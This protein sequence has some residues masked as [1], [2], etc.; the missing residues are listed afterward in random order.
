MGFLSAM[1]PITVNAIV[2]TVNV[3]ENFSQV[4]RSFGGSRFQLFTKVYLP[5]TIPYHLNGIRLGMGVSI[6]SVVLAEIFVSQ[7]GMG[8]QISFYYNNLQM[9]RMYAMLLILFAFALLLNLVL[10]K[11]QAHLASKGY[12]REE[13][14]DETG[15]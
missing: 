1:F 9:S 12:I 11:F 15:F 13:E 8:N 5:S 4:A 10:I 14:A 7:R 6:I 3:N 2:G